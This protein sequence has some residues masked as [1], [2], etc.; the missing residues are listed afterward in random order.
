MQNAKDLPSG[1]KHMC[2]HPVAAKPDIP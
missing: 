1:T 2:E